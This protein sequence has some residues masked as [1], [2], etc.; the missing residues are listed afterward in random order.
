MERFIESM[1]YAEYI[2]PAWA[3]PAW[4]FGPVW[5]LLYILIALSFGHVFYQFFKGRVSRKVALPFALNIIF[6]ILYTP[7]QF[8]IGNWEGNMP[9][10][11][12]DILLVLGT[13]IWALI[14]IWPKARMVVYLNI[15]YLLWVCFATALQISILVLNS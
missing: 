8:G 2:R 4:L 15:P 14:A 5:A 11:T 12:V 7:I 1:Q 10:A 6:N 9:L 13:L 3:P